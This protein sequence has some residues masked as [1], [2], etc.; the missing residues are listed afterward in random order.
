MPH[1]LPGEK[2]TGA[3]SVAFKCLNYKIGSIKR[4]PF[5]QD[6]LLSSPSRQETY[7]DL[8][9]LIFKKD[10]LIDYPKI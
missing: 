2:H 1:S 6:G 7:T 8:L 4:M 5:E 3:K 9:F 10:T